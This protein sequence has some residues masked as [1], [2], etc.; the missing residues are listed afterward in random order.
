VPPQD[1]VGC[2]GLVP[3]T[4]DPGGARGILVEA[5]RA[6]LTFSDVN[7]PQVLCADLDLEGCAC[8]SWGST[9]RLTI[10]GALAVGTVAPEMVEVQAAGGDCFASASSGGE[11]LE[12]ELTEITDTCVVGRLNV[13]HD[14][15]ETGQAFGFVAPRCD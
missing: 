9:L 5:E 3:P 15:A 11:V 6:V 13:T 7:D 8:E 1:I 4:E 10:D 14:F 12:L 2:E